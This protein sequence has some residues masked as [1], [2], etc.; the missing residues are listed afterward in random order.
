MH[1]S[2]NGKTTDGNKIYNIDIEKNFRLLLN[3]AV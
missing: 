1:D 2:I 3:K